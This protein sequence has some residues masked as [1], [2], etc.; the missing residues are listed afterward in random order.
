M[1]GDP[2]PVEQLEQMAAAFVRIGT[3]IG[4]AAGEMRK[5][6]Q[7]RVSLHYKTILNIRLPELLDWASKVGPSV[8]S[9]IAATKLGVTSHTELGK[10][11]Y[12]RRKK[13]ARAKTK[14]KKGS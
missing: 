2:I 11:A 3:A 5:E 12:E 1:A 7:Q 14:P 4:K 6:G 8:E 9:Q 10:A 13:N